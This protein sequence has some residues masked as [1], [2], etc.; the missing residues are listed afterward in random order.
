MTADLVSPLL[1]AARSI[2]VNNSAGSFNAI[3][4][5]KILKQYDF[6][7]MVLRSITEGKV[8]IF[9]IACESFHPNRARI[10]SI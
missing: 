8:E 10:I 9:T 6:A 7:L 3:V 5:T 2:F 4:F 1:F